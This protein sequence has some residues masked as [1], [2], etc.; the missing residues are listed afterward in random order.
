MPILRQVTYHQIAQDKSWSPTKTFVIL[1]LHFVYFGV[2]LGGLGVLWALIIDELAISKG[3]F[4]GLQAVPA[5]LGMLVLLAGGSITLRVTKKLI[6]ISGLVCLSA[7]SLLLSIV[8]NLPELALVMMTLG[9][10][11]GL[12]D[13]SINA[14]SIDWEKAT[15]KH[16]LNVMHAGFAGG[17][18]LG[19]FGTGWAIGLGWNYETVLLLIG[20]L[21]IL[22]ILATITIKYPPSSIEAE[23]TGLSQT[24]KLLST[25]K[26]LIFIAL[27]CS[28]GVMGESVAN[29][30]TVIY[31]RDLGASA[32]VGGTALAAFN[33]AMLL[34]RLLNAPFVMR[35]GER[36]SLV[37]SGIILLLANALLLVHSIPTAIA[38]FTLTG[39]GSAGVIPTALGLGHKVAPKT[40]SGAIAGISMSAV[41]ACFILCP[42]IVGLIAD[43][44]SLRAAMILIGLS[45]LFVLL[46]VVAATSS[47][48]DVD[49]NNYGASPNAT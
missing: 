39:L 40:D 17:A 33:G 46:L 44:V 35:F 9:I 2:N 49:V 14:A 25:H 37:T 24:V 48:P 19:S 23:G 47:P 8:G 12:M 30:W 20:I 34:G 1:L 32:S 22:A 13:L 29:L 15:S 27:I 16:A 5:F 45:G 3:V 4:G 43:S 7:G 42:P 6:G 41:Y 38:G 26:R 31:L 28:L 10:G 21:G 36:V 18:M 11:D